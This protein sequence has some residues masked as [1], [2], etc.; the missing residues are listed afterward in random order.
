MLG[1]GNGGNTIGL[2]V[3]AVHGCVVIVGNGN[4][5]GGLVDGEQRGIRLALISKACAHPF[6]QI[7]A[8]GHS[9]GVII[10]RLK[11]NGGRV[12]ILIGAISLINSVRRPLQAG[13]IGYILLRVGALNIK[14]YRI[15]I[16]VPLGDGNGSRP[17][18]L[19]ECGET[20]VRRRLVIIIGHRDGRRGV[21]DAECDAILR[22]VASAVGHHNMDNYIV[23]VFGDLDGL[24]HDLDEVF[25][26][27]HFVPSPPAVTT[28]VQGLIVFNDNC[29]AL[30]GS[31]RTR[32]FNRPLYASY[33]RICICYD[34]FD[35]NC[36]CI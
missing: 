22:N 6:G 32:Y 26:G 11:G 34:N 9:Q 13:D 23:A 17:G 3:I 20:I 21:V 2:K 18:S 7:F 15:G 27:I 29:S 31:L 16:K 25:L 24:L 33:A 5:G 10:I 28:I 35:G 8:G 12:G 30:S 36:S 14:L 19:V 1:N 4:G